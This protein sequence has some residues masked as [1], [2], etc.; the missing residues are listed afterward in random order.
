MVGRFS[1]KSQIS[2]ILNGNNTNNRG[3]NDVAGGM[4][5][6]M[7]GGGMGRG[8]GG[9]GGGN[10]ISTSWMGGLNGAWDL[11]DGD[12]ELS[13][14]YLY[15]G[16][17]RIVEEERSRLT[18]MNDGSQLFNN[19]VGSNTSASQGHRFGVRM[20]HDFSENTSMIFEPQF[21]FGNGHYEEHS[22]FYTDRIRD[23]VTSH[24]NEGFTDNNGITGLQADSS[25]SVRSSENP[26]ERFPSMS[27]TTSETTRW[28]D[29]TSRLHVPTRMRTESG[30]QIRKLSTRG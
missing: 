12:M 20:E 9:F 4:M 10:G 3:F 5:Q 2:V 8:S 25:F 13:G 22:E 21:N 24:S 26:E 7:R 6:E 16:S 28:T 27:V 30:M 19:N 15:N 17:N 1:D 29:S 18:Y 23:G 11:F 14:N